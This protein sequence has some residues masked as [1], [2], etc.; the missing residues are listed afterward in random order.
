MKKSETSL[1]M[2]QSGILISG[3]RTCTDCNTRVESS[4][5]FT[6][7]YDFYCEDMILEEML[8]EPNQANY[9]SSEN[10]WT[11]KGTKISGPASKR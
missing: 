1:A 2:A 10:S 11:F 8:R 7:K 6:G 3:G 5:I 9:D 4:E